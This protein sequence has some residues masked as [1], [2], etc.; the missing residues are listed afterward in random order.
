V[1]HIW[2]DVWNV[3]P[4]ALARVD[5]SYC[6]NERVLIRARLLATGL[7]VTLCRSLQSSS[8]VSACVSW[9]WS[10]TRGAPARPRFRVTLL[11]E[12]ARKW[13]GSSMARPSSYLLAPASTELAENVRP[14]SI[15]HMCEAL[16]RATRGDVKPSD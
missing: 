2:S 4:I 1:T 10:S 15:I 11:S 8:P 6:E 14:G 12:R 7:L 13:V 3:N 9:T 16:M 5:K